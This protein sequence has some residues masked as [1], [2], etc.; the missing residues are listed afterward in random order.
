MDK[1]EKIKRIRETLYPNVD[2]AT[3]RIIS[4]N[5]GTQ[6]VLNKNTTWWI[7][8]GI[9]ACVILFNIFK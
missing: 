4:I 3:V 2:G 5:K 7:V 8:G 6:R 1:R 9:I